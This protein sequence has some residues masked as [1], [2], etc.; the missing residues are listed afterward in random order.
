M[1]S[2]LDACVNNLRQQGMRR[3]FLDG[4]AAPSLDSLQELGQS[5]TLTMIISPRL[6]TL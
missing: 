3:M 4:V 2:L 6:L 1:V 5:P